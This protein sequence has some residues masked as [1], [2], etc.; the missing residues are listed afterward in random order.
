MNLDA[1]RVVFFFSLLLYNHKHPNYQGREINLTIDIA[2]DIAAVQ[3][4]HV[5]KV[6]PQKDFVDSYTEVLGEK[7]VK[8]IQKEEIG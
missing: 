2:L 5:K 4:F 8:R 7:H 6:S 3:E 1:Y